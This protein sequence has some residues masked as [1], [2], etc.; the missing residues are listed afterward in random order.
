MASVFLLSFRTNLASHMNNLPK[1]NFYLNVYPHDNGN[2]NGN[3]N[4]NDVAN[5]D[6][7][8]CEY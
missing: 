3:N 6:F 2:G 4:D 5:G 1:S 8:T 7:V